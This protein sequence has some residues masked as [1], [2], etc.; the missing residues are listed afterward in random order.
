MFVLDRVAELHR[1]PR[2]RIALL[3][4]YRSG[5]ACMRS[6][7]GSSVRAALGDASALGHLR[8]ELLELSWRS[9]PRGARMA[10]ICPAHP[11]ETLWALPGD[12]SSRPFMGRLASAHVSGRGLDHR[13]SLGVPAD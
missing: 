4:Y 10:W 13:N 8:R 12:I 7:Q 11:A 2:S 5:R 9:H 1:R 3:L 6:G